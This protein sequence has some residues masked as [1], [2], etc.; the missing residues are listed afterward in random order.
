MVVVRGKDPARSTRAA[1]DRLGGMGAFVKRGEVVV[2]KPNAA[3]DRVVAQAANTNPAVVS[4]VVRLCR[5]A[6]AREVWVVECSVHDS[7]RSMDRSGIR[8]AALEAG[9]QVFL[10]GGAAYVAVHLSDRLGSWDVL[11]PFVRADRVIN[12]PIAKHHGLVQVTA[13]M[14]NWIG[15]TTKGR[16]RWHGTINRSIVDL[17]AL[18]RPTLTVVDATRILLRN[19]PEGGNIDD[20]RQDD[21][22]AASIDPVA[23]DAWATDLLGIDRDRVKYLAMAQAEG[24]GQADYRALAF[25]QITT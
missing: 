5:D 16:S 14:K 12:V 11:E 8:K 17:A 18:M 13:G 15:I 10:P 4:E 3:W 24:L 22:V 7:E 19:G 20:V 1:V 25:E 9:G 23:V 2:I 21:M 6:G